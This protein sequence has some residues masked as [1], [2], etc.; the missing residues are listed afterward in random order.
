MLVGGSDQ[1]H[2]CLE[3]GPGWWHVWKGPRLDQCLTCLEQVPCHINVTQVWSMVYFRPVFYMSHRDSVRPMS[4]IWKETWVW[5]I[6]NCLVGESTSDHVTHVWGKVFVIT[7]SRHVLNR[8]QFR[9]SS[10]LFQVRPISSQC[11]TC[12]EQGSSSQMR[13]STLKRG[14]TSAYQ[15]SETLCQVKS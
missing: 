4:H 14:V 11:H 1:C 5:Q 7:M 3:K 12:Q 6:S 2:T 8:A 13:V 15:D 9:P 10:H